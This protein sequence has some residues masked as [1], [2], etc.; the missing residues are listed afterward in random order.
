MQNYYRVFNKT[1]KITGF[2]KFKIGYAK[3]TNL[4]G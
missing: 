4:L 2:S 1:Y 3:I